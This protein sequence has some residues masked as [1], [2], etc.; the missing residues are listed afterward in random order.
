MAQFDYY[1]RRG[2]A[3]YWLD[4]Q[5]DLLDDIGIRFLIPLVPQEDAPKPIR[6]LNPSMTIGG[7][8][9]VLL[10]QLAGPAPIAE[11]PRPA[12]SL[13]DF[14]YEILNAFDFLITGV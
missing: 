3:G 4:C 9:Y 7:K 1:P 5:A 12:G 8:Q 2:K 14:R 11:L 13:A 6:Q 10:T